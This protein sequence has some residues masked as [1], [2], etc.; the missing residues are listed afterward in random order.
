MAIYEIS[1]QRFEVPDAVQGAQLEQTLT[2]LSTSIG[3]APAQQA[4]PTIDEANEKYKVD[5]FGLPAAEDRGAIA[6]GASQGFLMGFGDEI[7]A[8]GAALAAKAQGLVD[9]REVDLGDAYNDFY[10]AEKAFRENYVKEN[11]KTALAAEI[12]GGTLTGGA[13]LAK[14]VA[15]QGGK[16]LSAKVAA[17]IA[18]G[19]TQGGVAG[20]GFS[21][22]GERLE[23]AAQGAVLGGTIG[24]A[25][26]AAGAAIGNRVQAFK[27][28]SEIKKAASQ[29]FARRA[30]GDFS[31]AGSASV[32][33]LK[34]NAKGKV[35]SDQIQK[36]TLKQGFDEGTVSLAAGASN[37]DKSKMVKMLNILQSSKGSKRF[38]ALNRTDDVIGGSIKSRVDMVVKANKVAGQRIGKA[39]EALSGK[40]A[41]FSGA[42]NNFTSDLDDIGVKLVQKEGR[43][44]PDF[45][46][47]QI[48][49]NAASKKAIANIV[50]RM[51]SVEVDAKQGHELKKLIDDIVTYGKV[52]TGLAGKGEAVLKNL[53]RNID[54]T[55]DDSFPE[56]KQANDLYA[57]TITAIDNIK[58][59]AGSKIDITGPNADKALGTISRGMLSNNRG[60]QEVINNLD[61]LDVLARDLASGELGQKF[62]SVFKRLDD[63]LINQTIFAEELKQR[64]GAEARTSLAGESQKAVKDGIKAAAG[65]TASFVDGVL[66]KVGKKFSSVNDEEAF[67]AMRTLL[68]A[69]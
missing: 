1:G 2:E 39:S 12:V 29:V 30:A 33:G 4:A 62:P 46:S 61:E 6:H 7:N 63:D 58:S 60:R 40:P 34:L 52:K 55:L 42:V 20:A 27:N 10:S 14:G 50:K 36:A 66:G 56:Y 17:G 35:V 37:A 9:G 15:T 44:I 65:D 32:A 28:N 3:A 68:L 38:A 59:S 8:A 45:A 67:K 64:F 57:K 25:L 23:G 31:D 24:G 5:I 53:R 19:A 22:Q 47:S 49:F 41:D 13:G 21:D 54:Q 69:K 16:R 11:P 51:G 26:P 43:I 18:T 48:E